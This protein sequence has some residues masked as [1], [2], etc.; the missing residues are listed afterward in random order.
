LLGNIAEA[1]FGIGLTFEKEDRLKEALQFIK[2]AVVLEQDNTEYL[3]VL[4]AT[5]YKMS[6]IEEAIACYQDI[7]L[8]DPMM[9]DAWLDWSY[10]LFVEN[11][12]EEAADII[13][14]AIKLNTENHQSQYRIATYLYALG[15]TKQAMMHLETALSINFDD[16]FLIFEI[17]PQLQNVSDILSLIALYKEKNEKL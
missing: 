6:H 12:Q 1:W 17:M 13:G 16:H 10:V 14:K 3:L 11:K 5:E 7:I 9:M 8:L 2:R 15:K 4:G